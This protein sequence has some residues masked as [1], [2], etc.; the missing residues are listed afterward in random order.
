M[1][2]PT[3]KNQGGTGASVAYASAAMVQQ[4]LALRELGYESL[5]QPAEPP[6]PPTPRS[7]SPPIEAESP[8]QKRRRY[9]R[10]RKRLERK[11]AC[12]KYEDMRDL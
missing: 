6:P 10:L 11:A 9:K 7:Y 2:T 3:I 4:H 8:G 5:G 12:R 1:M